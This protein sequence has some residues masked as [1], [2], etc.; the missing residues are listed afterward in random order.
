[1]LNILRSED[2]VK[3][4][5]PRGPRP[6]DQFLAFQPVQRPTNN[7]AFVTDE[8][9]DLVGTGKTCYVAIHEG[10]YIPVTEQR[11]AHDVNTTLK[12]RFQRPCALDDNFDI[13]QSCC[14]FY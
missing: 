7:F 13:T 9:C 1:M 8:S 10:E 3:T 6:L 12:R 11:D 2:A 5:S 4:N 14:S